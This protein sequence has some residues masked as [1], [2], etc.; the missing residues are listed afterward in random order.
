MQKWNSNTTTA[1]VEVD[2]P[3]SAVKP[4]LEKVERK[5]IKASPELEGVLGVAD[6][7]AIVKEL[8]END[9]T[10]PFRA[11]VDTK[12]APGYTDIIEEPMDLGTI[13][14]K[15]RANAYENNTA[16][17]IRDIRL[18]WRNCMEYN[19]PGS[20]IYD[21]A[22]ELAKNFEDSI[23][24]AVKAN[25][26]KTKPPVSVAL[27]SAS[28]AVKLE[29]KEPVSE[30]I[31][32]QVKLV[33]ESMYKNLSLHAV[34]DLL[35]MLKSF[36]NI[37]PF[38]EP[39]SEDDAPGYSAMIKFPMDVMTLEKKFTLGSYHKK[40]TDFVNDCRLL[41]KNCMTYNLPDSA[42]Y[43][44][45]LANAKLF[46]ENLL[47]VIKRDDSNYYATK[48]PV[49]KASSSDLPDEE[50]DNEQVLMED[51]DDGDDA[52]NI[53]IVL[54]RSQIGERKST[55]SGDHKPKR[56]ALCTFRV[57]KYRHVLRILMMHELAAPFVELQ[58]N[59]VYWQNVEHPLD[60]A[61]IKKRISEYQDIPLG[62]LADLKL[63]FDNWLAFSDRTSPIYH[64][65]KQLK[66]YVVDIFFQNF[67]S[68]ANFKT[69]EDEE[70]IREHRAN[71][72]LSRTADDHSKKRSKDSVSHDSVVTYTTQTSGNTYVGSST[73]SSSHSAD[74]PPLFPAFSRKHYESL[75]EQLNAIVHDSSD[76]KVAALRAT[77]Q[78]RSQQL[79]K[80]TKLPFIAL[81]TLYEVAEFGTID[82]DRSGSKD[83]L[84]PL[85]Y[86]CLRSM[87]LSLLPQTVTED[88]DIKAFPFV[89]TTFRS[90][91]LA[92]SASGPLRFQVELEN[93]VIVGEG[94]SP[95][96]AWAKV[97]DQKLSILHSIGGKLKRCRAVLNRLCISPDCEP[98]L[99]QVELTNTD[100]YAVIKA[101]MWFGEVYTRLADGTYDNE[102]DFAWD[103]RLIFRNCKEY[104]LSS[105]PVYKQADRLSALFEHLFVWWVIN[106]Q[107]R[108][109]TQPATG[110]W[111]SWQDLRYFD[112]KNQNHHFCKGTQTVCSASELLQCAACDDE[113]LPSAV[114]LPASRAN[115][116]AKWFCERCTKA[117]ELSGNNLSGLPF[118]DD[119]EVA[120]PAQN[121]F[122][123]VP[124]VGVGWCQAKRKQR[125]G[126]KNYFLSPLGYEISSRDLASSKDL[127]EAQKEF[128]VAVD[129]DLLTARTKEFQDTLPGKSSGRKGR[130]RSPT[131]TK[132]A[133][134][135]RANE[136][137]SSNIAAD[138][139][140]SSSLSSLPIDPKY[141]ENG[142]IVAGKLVNFEV[143]E[144]FELVFCASTKE[145]DILARVAT[146]ADANDLIE[147]LS[148]IYVENLPPYGFYG[149]HIPTIRTRLE[150]L[151]GALDCEEY[152]FLNG[153]LLKEDVIASLQAEIDQLKSYSVAEENLREVL[154]QERWSFEKLKSLP[155]R[156]Q[157]D[158]SEANNPPVVK[159]GFRKLFPQKQFDGLEIV[160]SVWD[161]LHSAKAVGF[162]N[163][164][165]ADIVSSTQPPASSLHSLAQSVF[166]EVCCI[167][168]DLLFQELKWRRNFVPTNEQRW[169][170]ITL[171]HPINVLTWP[172]IVE[173]VLL[174]LSMP[175]T[176]T[177]SDKILTYLAH[178]QVSLQLK[179][180]ALLY[181]HP[182][183]DDF[184]FAPSGSSEH[185]T[186][187]KALSALRG[188][189]IESLVSSTTST[190]GVENFASLL[191]A[192]F[193]GVETSG[194]VSDEVSARARALLS[195]LRSLLMRIGLLP[196]GE[197]L[198]ETA[199]DKNLTPGRLER[200]WGGYSLAKPVWNLPDV[201]FPSN[202]YREQS[203]LMVEKM[204]NLMALERTLSLLTAVDPE[205]W[206]ASDRLSVY[207]TFVDYGMNTTEFIKDA[208]VRGSLL[209]RFDSLDAAEFDV[210]VSDAHTKSVISVPKYAVCHFTGVAF[211]AV[212]DIAKWTVVPAEYLQPD[213]HE[214]KKAA[215][216]SNTDSSAAPVSSSE[217]KA[218]TSQ[219][220]AVLPEGGSVYMRG[221][222]SRGPSSDSPAYALKDA[223]DRVIN[224]RRLAQRDRKNYETTMTSLL[225]SNFASGLELSFKSSHFLRSQPVGYDAVG[226]VYWLLHVQSSMT[227]FHFDSSGRALDPTDSM[228]AEPCVIMQDVQGT[229]YYYN[230][231]LFS[232]LVNDLNAPV[233]SEKLLRLRLIEKFYI[234]YRN[235]RETTL[236]IKPLQVIW[237]DRKLSVERWVS[238]TI[239]HTGPN[240]AHRCRILETLWARCSE[241]RM[242]VYYAYLFKLDDDVERT[243]ERAER[244]A[245]LR[246]Q[247]RFKEDSIEDIFDLHPRKGWNRA[248]LFTRF[249][250]LAACTTAT[251]LHGDPT[252]AKTIITATVSKGQF[253]HRN[254]LADA[255]VALTVSSGG[256][257]TAADDEDAVDVDAPPPSQ[258]SQQH[259]PPRA[260]SETS[261]DAMEVDNEAT[262]VVSSTDAV[263]GSGG[264]ATQQRLRD[265]E[266][267]MM[268][269]E[270]D[271]GEVDHYSN[272]HSYAGSQQ[273]GQQGSSMHQNDPPSVMHL[274][275]PT[276]DRTSIFPPRST[277]AV[278]QLHILTGEV[279]R[280]YP[281]GKHAAT[282]LNVSQ[283]GISQCLTGV[284]TDCYGFR[285]RYYSGPPIDCKC[286]MI[287][288]RVHCYCISANSHSIV[289]TSR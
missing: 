61:T 236:G 165:L 94:P 27:K 75:V 10:I 257:V 261:A 121:I 93:G 179:A 267:D 222:R 242:H 111:D 273:Y 263:N 260:V 158:A 127:I 13:K 280:I 188:A 174:I 229:W 104:N 74:L 192:I 208:V 152:E 110:L 114:G 128:E 256:R 137:K 190:K 254:T 216:V 131:K 233:L 279:L 51:D 168:T 243:S 8:F 163:F 224:C 46:E 17:A 54:E 88:E 85:K 122:V 12:F 60:L 157:L 187:S 248:D 182:L 139:S 206:V 140:P 162:V 153:D 52:A 41:W 249:R 218:S 112:V 21:T 171:V 184:V 285:W 33:G 185:V 228:T 14:K 265:D 100:Y 48:P 53:P 20:E 58:A 62:F 107:D 253:L 246:K 151:D 251:K 78:G 194:T 239:Q 42:I 16:E 68:L 269:D 98:F 83:A 32:A 28:K 142:R 286:L 240:E 176:Q 241:I 146:G 25:A 214:G 45:A 199:D 193:E 200:Y 283:S 250:Q 3:K 281:S 209:K 278:E 282:F 231:R 126:L 272:V 244:E 95:K 47:I 161:F 116:K 89:L 24:N 91:V 31:D 276:Y 262:E 207:Q 225:Q 23:T 156:P 38:M 201:L 173:K 252:I 150:G 167:F 238:E 9:L 205:H 118:P 255:E 15:L 106:I 289:L 217:E 80:E 26:A 170:D 221:L 141:L 73:T 177:E 87:R 119:L 180:L 235:L 115:S 81:P 198:V 226:N 50:E 69:P 268:M 64:S 183:I 232:K 197:S 215:S 96:D 178:G 245:M 113:Y 90:R 258:P 288:L 86:E 159:E 155:D 259:Q 175:L 138:V 36:R 277:K 247:R 67:L 191:C 234:I 99:E 275:V 202:V 29:V 108:S 189:V 143:P 102:F 211:S 135:D 1:S 34:T 70:C 11:P 154:L 271:D 203:P 55:G 77:A 204:K 274:N 132:R 166:D 266:Q 181:N 125:G 287:S 223:L 109:S 219:E 186:A 123:A 6:V 144:G 172:R 213:N 210:I 149:F 49:Y 117:L 169:Q 133:F 270:D 79:L 19:A 130:H 134:L 76:G 40:P 57:R 39:V 43:N 237:L 22:E 7:K 227:L 264:S 37:L 136:E 18:V 220:A 56:K 72:E 101:P 4:K 160:L 195:W 147:N 92:T 103:V 2:E 59:P 105:S 164:T 82:L 212:P 196:H 284:K 97:F 145:E 124:E 63:V 129:Q 30:A 35:I 230:A 84:F 71:R 120:F 5:K 66:S 44:T 65:A 148:R